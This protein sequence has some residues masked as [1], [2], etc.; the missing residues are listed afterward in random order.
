MALSQGELK[1]SSEDVLAVQRQPCSVP[2]CQPGYIAGAVNIPS[3]LP[4]DSFYSTMPSSPVLRPQ[5]LPSITDAAIRRTSWRL[6]F[7]SEERSCQLRAP[8]LDE[9]SHVETSKPALT[10]PRSP[11]LIWLRSQGLRLSSQAISDPSEH[12]GELGI[13]PSHNSLRRSTS[14]F[15]GVDGSF[16]VEETPIHLWDMQ[17]PQRL[18]SRELYSYGSSPQLSSWGSHNYCREHS[19]EMEKSK[20]SMA[21]R[22]RHRKTS[23]SGDVDTVTSRT[24][25]KVT[26]EKK[27]S[28][29]SLRNESKVA[30]ANSSRL[31]LSCHLG[32]GED[33][34]VQDTESQGLLQHINVEKHIN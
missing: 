34:P 11:A 5:R 14:D 27:S 31:Y 12:T 17:I 15:G 26:C 1:A 18:R 2:V 13:L 19:V 9:K 4:M 22:S 29:C 8:S 30:T 33:T 10:P 7:A 32:C 6:S 3:S 25:A 24:W 21:N 20:F 28:V 23:S 16:E